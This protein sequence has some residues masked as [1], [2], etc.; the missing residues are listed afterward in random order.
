MEILRS[1]ISVYE[2]KLPRLK[3]AIVKL[4]TKF[5]TNHALIKTNIGVLITI[6]DSIDTINEYIEA[7]SVEIE[8][9]YA[10]YNKDNLMR[11]AI[12]IHTREEHSKK[13]KEYSDELIRLKLGRETRLRLISELN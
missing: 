7:V 12:N 11:M 1:Q 9:L 10:E 13:W 2:S 4:E 5:M 8:Y 6:S 3:D